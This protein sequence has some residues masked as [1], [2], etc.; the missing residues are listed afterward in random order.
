MRL[1]KVPTTITLPADLREYME[2]LAWMIEAGDEAVTHGSDDSIQWENCYG[3]PSDDS[4]SVFGFTYFPA[5]TPSEEPW[6]LSLNCEQIGK[7]AAGEITSLEGW[8]CAPSDCQSRFSHQDGY[9]GRC[10]HPLGREE[11]IRQDKEDEEREEKR[12]RQKFDDPLYDP[13]FDR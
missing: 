1:P 5:E 3:G 4:R 11:A 7:I 10:D 12:T 6:Q 9:C 8:R 13:D 2:E